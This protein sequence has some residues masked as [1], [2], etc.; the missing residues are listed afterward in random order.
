MY[1]QQE[2]IQFLYRIEVNCNIEFLVGNKEISNSSY[3]EMYT[4]VNSFVSQDYL[5]LEVIPT[6]NAIVNSNS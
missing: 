1:F 4:Q 3:V 2:T 6:E 5:N